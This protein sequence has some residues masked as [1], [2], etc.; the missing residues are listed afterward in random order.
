M[1]KNTEIVSFSLPPKIID[2]LRTHAEKNDRTA[3]GMLT[4]LL[5]GIIK[6]KERK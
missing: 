2:W 1:R 4:H 6:T 3:S 5:T